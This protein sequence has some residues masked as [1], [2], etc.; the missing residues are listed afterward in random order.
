MP[1][2]GNR[3]WPGIKAGQVA[4]AS[5]MGGV[6]TLDGPAGIN[7]VPVGQNARGQGGVAIEGLE[8]AYQI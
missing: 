5:A 3:F 6:A 8:V 7:Q 2:Y 1:G 4:R